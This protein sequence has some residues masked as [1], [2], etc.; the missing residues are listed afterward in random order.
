VRMVSDGYG[1]IVK[2]KEL[3]DKEKIKIL[4]EWSRII[5]GR[6]NNRA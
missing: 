5:L 1:N 4:L 6:R 3:T 2:K